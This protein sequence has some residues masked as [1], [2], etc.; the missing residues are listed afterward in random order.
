MDTMRPKQI[1]SISYAKLIFVLFFFA[2]SVS[3]TPKGFFWEV[4]TQKGKLYL[5]GSIHLGKEGILP[6]DTNWE[7]AFKSCSNLV[8]EV[9]TKKINPFRILKLAYFQDSTTLENVLPPEI[10]AKVDSMFA[11]HKIPKSTFN[12]F[13]P[14]FALTNLMNL[15]YSNLDF[16]AD[17]GI[18]QYFLGKADSTKKIIELESFEE[19]IQFMEN[20]F[21]KH[22]RTYFEY[23]IDEM[24]NTQSNIQDLFEGWKNGNDSLVAQLIFE[25]IPDDTIGNQFSDILITQRNK[26]MLEKIY[27]FINNGGC[28]FIIVGT[29]HLIGQ[30][31]IIQS[32]KELG[33]EVKRK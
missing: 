30:E 26:K 22:P 15:E 7:N 19:Q 20:L 29:G 24:K 14:W 4:T 6:L 1:S 11:I 8:V 12:K 17:F 25:S 5:L 32:L 9:N 13:R 2:Q 28:Y 31:G 18:D 23:F 16:K 27:G 10:F 33:F 21:D 3:P